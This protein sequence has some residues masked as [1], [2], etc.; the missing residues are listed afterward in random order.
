MN[1]IGALMIVQAIEDERRRLFEK[2]R[3]SRPGRNETTDAAPSSSRP[4]WREVL[5]FSRLDSATTRG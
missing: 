5:R 1:P 2:R 3:H 4:G